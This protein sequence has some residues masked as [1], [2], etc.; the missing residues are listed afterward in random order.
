MVVQAANGSTAMK[1]GIASWLA[2]ALERETSILMDKDSI[3]FEDYAKAQLR[4]GGFCHQEDLLQRVADDQRR[5]INKPGRHSTEPASEILTPMGMM[6]RVAVA[7][8]RKQAA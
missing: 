5:K 6:R 2:G 4:L 3:G 8:E 1:H 7:A